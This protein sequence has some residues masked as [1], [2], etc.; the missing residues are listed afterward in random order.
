MMM[1]MSDED[2]K[3]I[4]QGLDAGYS[5]DEIME[6]ME[7]KEK[8]EDYVKISYD[9]ATNKAELH[10]KTGNVVM[11]II[12]ILSSVIKNQN[13]ANDKLIILQKLNHWTASEALGLKER[14]EESTDH[15]DSVRVTDV[16]PDLTEIMRDIFAKKFSEGK[17]ND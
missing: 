17:Q 9:S 15:K 4:K 7:V 2:K 12:T 6:T 13:S 5:F 16:S 10:G 8:N 3:A 14:Y 11:A 1:K